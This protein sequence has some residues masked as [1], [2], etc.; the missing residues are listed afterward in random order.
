MADKKRLAPKKEASNKEKDAP[1][2]SARYCV[3]VV[4]PAPGGES[5][6]KEAG[7]FRTLEEAEAYVAANPQWPQLQARKA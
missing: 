4:K 1:K 6:F 3:C 7:T 2:A 5:A